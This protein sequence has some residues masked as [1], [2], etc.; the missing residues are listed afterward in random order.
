MLVFPSVIKA[1][2][3]IGGEYGEGALRA[4]DRITV[5]VSIGPQIG[6]QTRSQ[7]ILFMTE[8]ALRQFQASDGFE[9]GADGSV[10]L[11]KVGSPARSTPPRWPTSR[12]LP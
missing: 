8:D 7:I 10:A 4:G 2:L 12:W 5:A 6:A 11:V 3:G 1:G 9:I